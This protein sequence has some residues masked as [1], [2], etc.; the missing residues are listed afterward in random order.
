MPEDTSVEGALRER[1]STKERAPRNAGLEME[2]ERSLPSFTGLLYGV[3]V[4]AGDAE[5]DIIYSIM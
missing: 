5:V 4:R 3:D 2:I 1:Q